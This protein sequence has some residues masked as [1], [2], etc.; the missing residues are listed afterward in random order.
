[1]F[2]VKHFITMQVNESNYGRE[3]IVSSVIQLGFV[4]LE[5]IDGEKSRN[6]MFNDSEGLMGIEELSIQVLKTMFEV[7]GIARVEVSQFEFL[8]IL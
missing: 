2:K 7:H 3:Q 4:L 8:D 6:E 5:N 1:M